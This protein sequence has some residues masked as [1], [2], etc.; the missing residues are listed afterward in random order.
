MKK[1]SKNDVACSIKSMQQELTQKTQGRQNCKHASNFIIFHLN[2]ASEIIM[3]LN[4][5]GKII[6]QSNEFE[7]LSTLA[8][9]ALT[10]ENQLV[11]GNEV[12]SYVDPDALKWHWSL[13]D[14][15]KHD[16]ETVNYTI[17]LEES[18]IVV[19]STSLLGL[20]LKQ[21]KQFLEHQQKTEYFEA[22]VAVPSYLSKNQIAQVKIGA[23]IAGFSEICLI[24]SSSAIAQN[25]ASSPLSPQDK[26]EFIILVENRYF[27]DVFVYSSRQDK[28]QIQGYSPVKTVV[29][30]AGD[31]YSI[32]KNLFKMP[33]KAVGSLFDFCKTKCQILYEGNEYHDNINKQ[34]QS[35]IQIENACTQAIHKARSVLGRDVVLIESVLINRE[36]S[37]WPS[38]LSPIADELKLKFHEHKELDAVL[39]GAVAFWKTG[40]KINSNSSSNHYDMAEVEIQAQKDILLKIFEKIEQ[41]ENI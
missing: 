27:I 25:Y 34:Q 35:C 16:T 31:Y 40:R 19:T 41:Q 36:F 20:T 8:H 13:Y 38:M 18:D 5:E 26:G 22:I 4:C 32:A 10:K 9:I 28:G 14:V 29:A 21:L 2:E 24:N 3:A 1:N 11:F 39:K 37:K 7:R 15:F 17:P 23:H 30:S 6:V 33:M 12:L